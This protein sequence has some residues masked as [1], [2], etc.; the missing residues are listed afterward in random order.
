MTF[1]VTQTAKQIARGAVVAAATVLTRPYLPASVVAGAA[2]ISA[3]LETSSLVAGKGLSAAWA[4]SAGYATKLAT[5]TFIKYTVLAL[6][7]PTAAPIVAA[8][9]I[10]VVVLGILF[11]SVNFVRKHQ[12]T[13]AGFLT[14]VLF[15]PKTAASIA[16]FTK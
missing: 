10:G 2:K 5:W 15:L 3:F 8:V 7:H 16:G 9:L 6:A 1:S 11:V 4:F 13:V 12:P 14:T